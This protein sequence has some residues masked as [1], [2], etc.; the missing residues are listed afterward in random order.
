MIVKEQHKT[1]EI[2]LKDVALKGNLHIPKNASGLVIF[3]HGS[4]SSRLSPRN[5]Y[6]AKI[7]QEQGMGTLLFD[8]LTKK[9]DAV[10]QTRFDIDLLTQRLIDTTEWVQAQNTTKALPLCYFGAST[11]A[12]SA[13]R[14]A[15]HFGDSIKAVV[16]RGGRADMAIG[17]LQKVVAPTLLIVG[18]WDHVV[19]E[20]NQKAYARLRCT[21]KLEI[22]PEATH[23]FEAPGKLEEVAQISAVWFS[24]WLESK[25]REHVQR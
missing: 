19:L 13:L 1:I 17:D 8:L 23:L 18:D 15:A 11:G 22:I 7:L 3:S 6:V 25:K 5:N 24:R 9:E 14:A 16:S 2:P 4:G 21:K 20:L 10:Y 12:A